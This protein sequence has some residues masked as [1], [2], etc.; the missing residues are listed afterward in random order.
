MQRHHLSAAVTVVL[1]YA[2]AGAHAATAASA[3]N[4]SAA[5]SVHSAQKSDA[6]PLGSVTNLETVK[7]T[8]RRYEETLQDV[9]IAVTAL[10]ARAL[11]DN[12]VQN[13]A[14]LQGLVPNLQIGPTQGTTSTLTVYLRGIGQ[15]NPLWGFDPEVGL[16]LDGVYIARPQG[17]LLNVF[18]VDRIE[19]LR[20]PQGTLYGKNTVGG[21][22]NFI[23]KPLPTHETGSVTATLGM[24]ATRD[25]KVDYGN[26]SKDGVWRFRVAAATLHHGGY[27]HDL[28]TGSPNSNQNVNAARV[29]LG[30]FPS[31]TFNAQVE[32]DGVSDHSNPAG[33]QRLAIIPFD[34]AHTPQLSNPWNTQ[35]DQPP[36]NLSNSG[37][38]ALTL[39]WMPSDNWEFKSITAYRS[40]NTN[41]NIDVDT[42][43]VSIADNN[44]I[45]HSHQF[46]QE[47]QALYD[48][49]SDL[50]GVMGVYYFNGYAG[51]VNK[52]ALLALPPYQQLGYSLYVG[53][54][55]SVDTHSLAAYADY[56][57]RFAPRWSLEAGA[58]YTHESKTAIIQNYTY[59]NATF[60]TPNGVQ[61]NF[62]GSTAANNLSPKLTLG[63]K[64]SDA[65]NLYATA[66]T[67]FH[68]GG[69]N[70][71]A[72]CT[73]IPQS[74]RPI[75]NETLLNYEL[76]A[77]MS[78][79]GGRLMLNSALFHAL[80]HNI[81]LSVYTSY[82]QPNGQR[83]FFGDFTN[84]GK[85]TIDGM[86]NEFAWQ[87]GDR[88]T[89]SGNLSY[90]HPRYT[91]YISGG[92]NI[93]AT[94]K[95]T[96]A[97]KWNGGLTLWKHFPLAGGGDVAARLNVTYQTLAYFDQNLSPV[98]AQGAYG[99]VNAGVIWHTGGAWTYSLEGSNL[100]DKHYRTS[101]FNIIALGM[102]TGYYGPPRMITMAA[103]YR[104]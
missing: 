55:G 99:L 3:G 76:G 6:P 80:Y 51:G 92:V 29:S 82:V 32:L 96:Y 41:M 91:Q 60:T 33:G 63:W 18:D 11:T 74:C 101:G 5:K 37:G 14:D 46:S 1:G 81:Q 7:V 69:Y 59:P 68:S 8:A 78:F 86:E 47:L 39:R 67:G 71:Q 90:L 97:P 64:A 22:I 98:L 20:G 104:F 17:A 49:G 26:A 66:S 61:A 54:G 45:Y 9:P 43:P 75:R 15:N 35:S 16:Y 73:A 40:S 10:T 65:V 28:L 100:A 19:V 62:E 53:S 72:N 70:I 34:P 87:M 77:K 85:A 36:V 83:G 24:H 23:S 84:A 42:L 13:L 38:G 27:G 2:V 30:Y 44:L 57:W 89:L 94:S 25:L 58:R 31:S 103:R 56:T 95:F 50:H 21:A 88:W 79:F 12:N 52:Y 48:N 4:Q 102:I 93:A